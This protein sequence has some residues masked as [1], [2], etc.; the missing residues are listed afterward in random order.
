MIDYGTNVVAGTR[1]GKGGTTHLGVPVFNTVR[2]AVEATAANTSII[3]VPAPGAADAI[4]EAA[5]AGIELIVCITEHIPVHDMVR[6]SRV[7]GDHGG[8]VRL[9]GPNCPGVIT[10]GASK[11]GIMP[12]NVFLPGNVGLVSRSGT[13]TYE[14]VD[15][16]SRLGIGQ[17]TC[18]GIG[19]DP[20]IG[21]NFVDCLRLF[22]EDPA[23]EQI[24]LIGEIGGSDEEDAA[25]FLAE[26]P[27]GHKPVVTFISGRSAPPGKRM[28]HAGAIISG[29]SGGPE[30][31]V[32]AFQ[33]IGVPVAG[34]ITEIGALV[35]EL[36]QGTAAR[37]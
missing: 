12:G 36:R 34:T 31:K 2:E 16:L 17:S 23:T 25:R 18:V 19:G 13:L 32:R 33:E 8:R 22:H 10:P 6:V 37:A 1:P 20:I 9:V 5:A 26:M 28:G 35:R 14:A 21:T 11:V 3:F 30:A 29:S 7:L 27:G 15:V 4:L 24:V